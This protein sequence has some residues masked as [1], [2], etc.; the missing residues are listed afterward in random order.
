MPVLSLCQ[1]PLLEVPYA[2]FS[3]KPANLVSAATSK[4]FHT[5]KALCFVWHVHHRVIT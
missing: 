2:W 5:V 1:E 3:F 4:V